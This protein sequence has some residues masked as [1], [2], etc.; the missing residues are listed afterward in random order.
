MRRSA[1]W[2]LVVV[3]LVTLATVWLGYRQRGAQIALMEHAQRQL[4]KKE[5]GSELRARQLQDQLD[6]AKGALV[7]N[8][9]KVSSQRPAATE[10]SAPVFINTEDMRKNP[11]YAALWR[12]DQLRSIPIRKQN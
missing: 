5:Q 11:R 7:A 4:D 12:Q 10:R 2:V 9:A 1:P 8:A 3:L 6:R